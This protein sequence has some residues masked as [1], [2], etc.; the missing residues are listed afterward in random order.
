M[1]ALEAETR[2]LVTELTG[3]PPSAIEQITKGVMTYKFLVHTRIGRL[4]VRFYPL[5]RE[6][7]GAV[8]PALLER[9]RSAGLMTPE[10]IAASTAD[11]MRYSIYRYI[12][13]RTLEDA[14]ST[15]DG[16]SLARL[17]SNV[18]EQLALLSGLTVEN[19]GDLISP[20]R[21]EHST[22]RHLVRATAKR[23]VEARGELPSSLREVAGR[24]LNWKP[25]P[26]AA[27]RAQL[28]WGDISP[29]HIIVDQCDRLAGL[30]DFE[31]VFVAHR[32]ATLGFLQARYPIP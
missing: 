8:E 32:A 11:R 10:V 17:A 31:G 9:F 14:A 29:E 16:A 6:Q 24:M 19:F 3:H 26:N 15:I 23:A 28:I 25:H 22:L 13:G 20:V 27:A 1:S 4:V 21:A 5:G 12:E 7:A 18:S 2:R 30:I